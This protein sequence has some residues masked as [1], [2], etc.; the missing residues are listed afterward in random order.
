M[1][2]IYASAVKRIQD[3]GIKRISEV[4][5]YDGIKVVDTGFITSKPEHKMGTTL[6]SI[7]SRFYHKLVED[8]LPY[9][10]DQL[11]TFPAEMR[12]EFA[13]YLENQREGL[14]RARESGNEGRA[15]I[16]GG[17]V[18]KLDSF[19]QGINILPTEQYL[20][21][22]EHVLELIQ[23]VTRKIALSNG[24]GNGLKEHMLHD[25]DIFAKALTLSV[26]SPKRVYLLTRDPHMNGIKRAILE[27]DGGLVSLTDS[28]WLPL[29]ENVVR[30]VN[31]VSE[32]PESKERIGEIKALIDCDLAMKKAA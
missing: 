23:I 10:N 15:R 32:L 1:S 20:E 14:R 29:D 6:P 9:A 16:L 26:Y 27:R 19:A 8:V 12:T 3:N 4:L 24:T 30:K 28:Y 11:V 7:V 31:V 25:A 5:G 17:L 13:R 22:K 18:G 2:N 21:G